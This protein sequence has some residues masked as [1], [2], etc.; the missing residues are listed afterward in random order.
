MYTHLVHKMFHA[1]LESHRALMMK[2][3]VRQMTRKHLHHHS[4]I[5]AFQ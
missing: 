5:P 3:Q 4:L 2:A 1:Q